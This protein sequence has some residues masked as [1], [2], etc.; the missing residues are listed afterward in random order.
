MKKLKIFV[1]AILR[2]ALFLAPGIGLAIRYWHSA[3]PMINIL[4]AIGVE[5]ICGILLTF[6][7]AIRAQLHSRRQSTDI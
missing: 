4:A 7:I 6:Y 2:G 3:P 5:S 1:N